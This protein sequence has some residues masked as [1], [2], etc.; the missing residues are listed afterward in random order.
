LV[1]V[2]SMQIGGSI[3]TSEIERGLTRV[4]KGFGNIETKGKGV[5]ADFE[6][7]N[8]QSK[9][10]ATTLGVMALAGAGA[11]V[12]IAKGAPATAGAMARIKV[13]TMKL[14]FA[15]GTALKPHFDWFADKLSRVASWVS[16]NPDLFGIITTSVIALGGSFLAFKIGG[17]IYG[18]IMALTGIAGG[19]I[20]LVTSPAFL[21][22][23]VALGAAAALWALVSGQAES[24]KQT[25]NFYKAAGIK[26]EEVI[27][28][29]IQGYQGTIYPGMNNQ[30][31]YGPGSAYDFAQNIKKMS[32]QEFENQMSYTI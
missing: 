30:S 26:H 28:A 9:R 18:G 22:A 8:Q 13:S 25:E 6:R 17:A 27:Q 7:M 3:Q 19:L 14:Q 15:I 12:A 24:A 4:E 32:R 2:G 5:N 23:V 11:L 31:Y 10:L 1:E 21:A 29:S 20:A 16:A